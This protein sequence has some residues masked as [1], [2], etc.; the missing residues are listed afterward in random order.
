MVLF[1]LRRV[2]NFLNWNFKFVSRLLFPFETEAAHACLLIFHCSRIPDGWGHKRSALVI[3]ASPPVPVHSEHLL[4]WILFT[5]AALCVWCATRTSGKPVTSQSMTNENTFYLPSP[6]YTHA[7][8]VC[9][10][11]S[12]SELRSFDFAPAWR[13]GLNNHADTLWD[14]LHGKL[15]LQWI[16]LIFLG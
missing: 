5:R 9:C 13:S 2:S 14:A 6:S 15:V 12:P 3:S 16:S 10:I 1:S 8:F 11:N 7:F 4:P